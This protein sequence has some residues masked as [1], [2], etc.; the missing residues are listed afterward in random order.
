MINPERVELHY[1]AFGPAL[2]GLT[3]ELS[4]FGR[5][6]KGNLYMTT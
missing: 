5:L 2:A 4:V 6:E 1:L 3:F